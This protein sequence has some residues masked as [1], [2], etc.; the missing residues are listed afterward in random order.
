[1][2][3]VDN[4][5]ILEKEAFEILI[6]ELKDLYTID[7]TVRFNL[8]DYKEEKHVDVLKITSMKDNLSLLVISETLTYQSHVPFQTLL[9]P[10][11]VSSNE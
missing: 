9:L 6:D 1:M 8:K 4:V 2:G 7:K 3:L 5:A 10:M 11:R